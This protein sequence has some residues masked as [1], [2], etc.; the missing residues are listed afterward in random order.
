[1]QVGAALRELFWAIESLTKDDAFTIATFLVAASVVGVI[2]LSAAVLYQGATPALRQFGP[3]FYTGVDWNI[4]A[5]LFGTLPYILGT[6]VTSLIAIII[7]V[8]ISL[9]IAIFLAEMAPDFVRVPISNVVELLAAVPSIV[10]G[11]WGFYILRV[12][13]ANYV[14]GPIQ[15][16]FGS[17]PIFAGVSYGSNILTG[18]LIL[19]IMIIP[20]V[21][22]ISKEVMMSVPNSQREAAYSVGA[23]RWE[24]VHMGVLNYARS[25]IFGAAILGLGRA[26]GETMAVTL[27]IGGATGALAIP[28]SLFQPGQ[29]MTTILVNELSEAEPGSLHLSALL[30]IGLVL[31]AFAFVINVAAQLLVWRVLKVKGGSVE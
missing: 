6:L 30:G 17:V 5:N 7:G 2:G 24:V 21:S 26:V 1:M 14:Q 3:S 25:G 20:T 28:T 27:V 16:N 19:A 15:A 13:V 31:F 4:Q 29:T 9:G 22:S 10:Y 11:L 12:W 23:T 8:P 18:G